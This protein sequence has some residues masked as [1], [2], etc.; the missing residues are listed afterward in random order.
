MTDSLDESDLANKLFKLAQDAACWMLENVQQVPPHVLSVA[1]DG[2]VSDPYF[3][4]DTLE[5]AGWE[6]LFG[7]AVSRAQELMSSE[8]AIAVSV[9]VELENEGQRGVGIQVETASHQLCRILP[10]AATGA[11][12]PFGEPMIPDRLLFD[13][14]VPP[15]ADAG[16]GE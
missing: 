8:V 4:H 12:S 14:L 3:P 2:T 15:A 5:G 9:S 6:E 13:R 10:V 1:A 11:E 16:D 7:A